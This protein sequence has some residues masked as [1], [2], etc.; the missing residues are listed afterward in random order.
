MPD[1]IYT[2]PLGVG[3]VRVPQCPPPLGIPLVPALP[4]GTSGSSLDTAGTHGILGE[5]TDGTERERGGTPVRIHGVYR[6]LPLEYVS[7]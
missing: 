6:V 2:D 4:V 3:T 1:T 7:Y 5:Y